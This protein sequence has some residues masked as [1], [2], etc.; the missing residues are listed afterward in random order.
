MSQ[1]TKTA[2]KEAAPGRIHRPIVKHIAPPYM[3]AGFSTVT[4]PQIPLSFWSAIR[5]DVTKGGLVV[6]LGGQPNPAPGAPSY[7]LAYAGFQYQFTVAATP[8]NYSEHVFRVKFNTG[9]VT[10]R[11]SGDNSVTTF[12]EI[13]FVG[14]APR[15]PVFSNTPLTMYA[16]AYLNTGQTYNVI[17]KCG[18]E[19]VR[20]NAAE[21]PYGE[22]IIQ[23]TDLELTRYFDDGRSLRDKNAQAA[24]LSAMEPI[25]EE[26]G[27]IEEAK[28]RGLT[29]IF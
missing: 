19:I 8:V 2:T 23:D 25:I 12:C 6:Q 7:A 28:Q 1:A 29:A 5:H 20:Y 10:V 18:V 17:V 4:N 3:G 15:Q 11:N 21:V 13:Q 16:D 26:V 14:P 9:P 27:S 22:V 24:A